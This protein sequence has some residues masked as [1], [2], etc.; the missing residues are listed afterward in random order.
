[1]NYRAVDAPSASNSKI[2]RNDDERTLLDKLV[3]ER[4]AGERKIPHK[5]D[6]GEVG[7]RPRNGQEDF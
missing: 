1:M 2:P 7:H 6:Q 5:A 4:T 3:V